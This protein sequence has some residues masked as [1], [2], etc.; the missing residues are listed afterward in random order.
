M[1]GAEAT[2]SGWMPPDKW[3]ALVRGENCPLCRE[4]ASGVEANAYFTKISDLRTSQL[5]LAANQCIPGYCVLVH[6]K[7]VREPYESDAGERALFFEDMMTAAQALEQVFAPMKMNFVMNGISVPHLHC[8][9]LPRFR[10]DPW[11]H[12]PARPTELKIMLS[13][14]EYE[15]RAE[16]IRAALR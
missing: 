9:I 4:I 13:R 2:Q 7:H 15:D 1:P 8:H 16:R 5:R 12:A 3:E 11:P 6:K 14:Q 10:G